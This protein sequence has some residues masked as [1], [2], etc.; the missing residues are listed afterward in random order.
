MPAGLLSGEVTMPLLFRTFC[1]GSDGNCTFIS[2]GATHILID[3]GLSARAFES[4]MQNTGVSAADLC[5]ILVT[6]EHIDHC[7]GLDVIAAKYDIPVYA[8]PGTWTMLERKLVKRVPL[9]NRIP[10]DSAADFYIRDFNVQPF[11]TPHDCAEPVAYA[12]VNHGKRVV[13][14]T[15]MGYAKRGFVDWIKSAD[16]L[17]LESNYDP[18][19]LTNGRYSPSLKARIA[20]RFG[21][22]SNS[23]CS[24]V[25]VAAVT[26]GSVR[27]VRLGHLSKNNNTPS[28]ALTESKDALW[29]A[30]VIAGRDVALDIAPRDI[31]SEP[32]ILE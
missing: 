22:L 14:A 6:H 24:A 23:D 32:I 8:T 28:L 27:T 30:G 31:P 4:A 1:S 17:L 10:V 20:G 11:A 9:K 29:G 25:L 7:R 19:M 16:I 21:H 3:A 12:L 18:E 26:G 5:G 13:V 2:D 15:D